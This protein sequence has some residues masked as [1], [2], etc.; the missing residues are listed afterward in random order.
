MPELVEVSKR[1]ILPAFAPGATLPDLRGLKRHELFRM[2]QASV[3]NRVMIAI[4]LIELAD[5]AERDPLLQEMLHMIKPPPPMDD[6]EYVR[7][8]IKPGNLK[9]RSA[10]VAGYWRRVQPNYV[11]PTIPQAEHRLAVSKYGYSLFKTKGVK[12][13]PDG[14]QISRVVHSIGEKFRGVRYTTE[15]E[16]AEKKRRRTVERMAGAEPVRVREQQV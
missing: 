13:L 6:F 12:V 15:E 8:H 9:K 7:P 5:R 10:H 4:I 1:V 3:H 14:R 11:F 16:R 2:L